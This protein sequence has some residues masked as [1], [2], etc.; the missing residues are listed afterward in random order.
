[1]R[2]TCPLESL[3]KVRN[4]RVLTFNTVDMLIIDML[5]MDMLIIDEDD[6]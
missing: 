3:S 4:I 2:T 1:M 6:G 5:I